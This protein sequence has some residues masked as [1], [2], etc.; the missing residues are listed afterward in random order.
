MNNVSH[1]MLYPVISYLHLLTFCHFIFS[2]LS[3]IGMAGFLLRK[4][5]VPQRL[6]RNQKPVFPQRLLRKLIPGKK[7]VFIRRLLSKQ[8][9]TKK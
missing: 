7:Q 8:L 6:H 1:S 4:I 9:L 2:Y 5:V 3:L